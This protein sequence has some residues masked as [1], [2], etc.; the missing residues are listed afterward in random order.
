MTKRFFIT[1][2]ALLLFSGCDAIIN[3]PPS[4]TRLDVVNVTLLPGT[5]SMRVSWT[6]PADR[7]FIGVELSWSPGGYTMLFYKGTTSFTC[8][9]LDPGTEYTFLV[10]ARYPSGVLAPGVSVITSLNKAWRTPIQLLSGSVDPMYHPIAFDGSGNAI[11]VWLQGDSAWVNVW[12]NRYVPGAGWGT[13]GS[14]VSNNAGNACM[15]QIAIDNSGNAIAVWYQYNGT[16]CDIWANR[17]V[18]GSGWR[19]ASPIEFNDTGNAICPDRCRLW[20]IPGR[21]SWRPISALQQSAGK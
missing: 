14:I 2:F 6:E 18:S 4:P 3:P 1:I 17:Y 9:T 10:R 21:R 15:P 8:T 13:A 7:D 20:E 5:E 16:R 12:A 19:T 11:A